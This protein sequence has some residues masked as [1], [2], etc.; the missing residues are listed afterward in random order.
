MNI[1]QVGVDIAKS[2]FHVHGVD[3]HE[4]TQ[5]RGNYTR[6]KWLDAIVTCVPVGAEIAMEACASSHYWARELQVRGYHV[7]L[8]AA[9]FVK[10][11]VKSNKN[12]RVDAEAICEAM[13]RPTMRFVTVKTASQQ[14]I[15]ATHRIREELVKQR[16]A[17]ANQIRGL[18]GEYGLVAP[19]GIGQ[20][21]VALPRWLEDAESGLTDSF[22][23]LLAGLAEDLWYLDNRIST[24][25][26]QI[27]HHAKTDPVAKRLMTLRGVGTITASALAGALGDAQAFKRGRD[28]A[29]SLGLTPRQHST[30]GRD[31][32]L[33]ISK[34][35]DSYL[36]TLLVHGARA[37]LRYTEGKEDN[38]SHWVRQLAERKHTN[39]AVIALANKTA[40]IAWAITR[41]DEAYDPALAAY[42]A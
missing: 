42:T 18:V 6:D 16:T 22:R 5:W 14:D 25:T 13:G 11:Y 23:R 17:K 37:V 41:R 31:R 15:Q 4:Q 32:L 28:F 40:R 35:G 39:V 38:L 19:I 9:Q 26:E 8:I 29:A 20:L 30:G 7:K 2:V 10:P 24:V 1:T 36:R 34:R 21:R 27:A 3:R 12:D 33:G